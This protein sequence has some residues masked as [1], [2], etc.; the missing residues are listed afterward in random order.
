RA[1]ARARPGAGADLEPQ[2][3]GAVFLNK[4]L[5]LVGEVH[6]H[7]L[8]TVAEAVPVVE[9]ADRLPGAG[10]ARERA[11]NAQVLAGRRARDVRV[12][13]GRPAKADIAIALAP[14]LAEDVEPRAVSADQL[15]L[16][17]Q[18]SELVGHG[19]PN[20]SVCVPEDAAGLRVAAVAEVAHQPGPQRLRLARVDQLPFPAQ[21]AVHAR[22]L[23]GRV[24]DA[25]PEPWLFAGTD[26]TQIGG[27]CGGARGGRAEP[28][29]GVYGEKRRHGAES[30]RVDARAG[31]K[32]GDCS[33]AAGGTPISPSQ[34][35]PTRLY[36]GLIPTIA[37][38]R[39]CRTPLVA[40]CSPCS[41]PSRRPPRTGSRPP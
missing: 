27:E 19:F 34:Q 1:R 7:C 31:I 29:E 5:P 17:D 20:Q 10:S 6:R 15:Q 18:G 28:A 25:G 11:V 21:H 16:A 36:A 41:S 39:P 30:F 4:Q 35:L 33:P 26:P 9:T 3:A 38:T 24:A 8:R 12:R 37:R 40:P 32:R 22:Q 13:G 2:A 23:G 14:R